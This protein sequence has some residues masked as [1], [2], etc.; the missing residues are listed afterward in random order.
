[1]PR[2]LPCSS[3]IFDSTGM[4]LLDDGMTLWL[5]IGRN[6]PIDELDELF[7]P[8]P[9]ILPPDQRPLTEISFRT[10][11]LTDYSLPRRISNIISGLRRDRTN[12]PDLKIL[13]ADAPHNAFLHRFSLRLVE[14]SIYGNMSYVDY[15]VKTHAKI[16]ARL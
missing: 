15:L 7:D 13:W 8:N 1:M 2:S 4:Y 16:Q 12:I 5:Y 14:D 6:M 11:S 10:D 9:I 3:E